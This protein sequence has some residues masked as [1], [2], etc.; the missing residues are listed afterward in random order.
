MT[1]VK[2]SS[3]MTIYLNARAHSTQEFLHAY[4]LEEKFRG[5]PSF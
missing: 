5:K 3:I 4:G 2:L 1:H